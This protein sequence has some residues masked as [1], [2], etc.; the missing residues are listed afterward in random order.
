LRDEDVVRFIIIHD[1]IIMANLLYSLPRPVW[2]FTIAAF[3]SPTDLLLLRTVDKSSQAFVN[4]L[5]PELISALEAQ[6]QT[7][8]V[9][10]PLE[11]RTRGETEC[12]LLEPVRQGILSKAVQEQGVKSLLTYRN[13]PSDIVAIFNVIHCLYTGQQ[14]KALAWDEL[15]LFVKTEGLVNKLKEKFGSPTIQVV[16]E[17]PKYTAPWFDT[18]AVM[19]VSGSVA[20]LVEIAQNYIHIQ[21]S[22]QKSPAIRA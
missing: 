16:P 19:F 22:Y 20:G 8:L 5:L 3:L 18:Q 4:F 14:Q 6:T 17:N 9:S 2:T 1:Q 7:L 15:A 21:Q 11:T 12:N 13:P 10:V